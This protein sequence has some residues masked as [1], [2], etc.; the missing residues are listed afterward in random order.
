MIQEYKHNFATR[1]LSLLFLLLTLAACGIKKNETTVTVAIGGNPDTL[2]PHRTSATITKQINHNIYDMLVESDF[3]PRLA[4]KWSISKDRLSWTFTLRDDVFFHHGK[5]FSAEDV[6]ATIDR[7]QNPEI[8]SPMKEQFSIIKSAYAEDDY[9]VTMMLTKPSV[10]ILALFAEPQS[11][12]LPKDII[13]EKHN[14]NRNPIGTGPFEFSDWVDNISITLHKNKNYTQTLDIESLV[15]LVIADPTVVVQAIVKG[16]VDVSSVYKDPELSQIRNT[17]HMKVVEE[18]GTTIL[19]LAM[20]MRKAL[21]S[22][23]GFR[24][25]VAQSIDKETVL[26]DA[27]NGGKEVTIFWPNDT[28]YSVSKKEYKTISGTEPVQYNPSQ[29]RE[30]FSAYFEGMAQEK[31]LVITVPQAYAP[32]VQAA[33]LYQNM[34]NA[35]GLK[36]TIEL[37][38][39]PTWMSRVYRK[40]V[41]DFTVIGHTGKIAPDQ[42]LR[43]YGAGKGYIGWNDET[44]LSILEFARTVVSNEERAKL[45][46]EAFVRM[47][48]AQPFVFVGQT[49]SRFAH[50]RRIKNIRRDPI[51][52]LYD[53]RDVRIE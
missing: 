38:D 26:K 1:Y 44:F 25:A 2:D 14:F 48:D 42:R 20:N 34:F 12:I 43:G 6:I 23:K 35:V 32:H 40:G 7:I 16:E 51:L 49:L 19:V 36:T 50:H 24:K 8:D 15:F 4:K 22:H 17:K 21:F 29:A 11:A 33:Q 52:E 39:W 9:T 5:K 47:S 31:P 3:S 37:V 30:Y 41:F 45:Y 46:K 28:P 18:N 13:E 10:D 53:F 27:Y